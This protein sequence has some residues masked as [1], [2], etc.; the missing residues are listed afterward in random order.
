MLP[1]V[2]VLNIHQ[3]V[4]MQLYQSP[5]KKIIVH[6]QLFFLMFCFHEIFSKES[7]TH[8]MS[9]GDY[10]TSQYILSSDFFHYISIIELITMK[11]NYVFFLTDVQNPFGSAINTSTRSGGKFITCIQSQ[12]LKKLKKKYCHRKQEYYTQ[13]K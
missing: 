7:I 8:L 6:L 13:K 1:D 9:Q 4:Q 11:S 12:A 2:H 3:N 5:M 10:M